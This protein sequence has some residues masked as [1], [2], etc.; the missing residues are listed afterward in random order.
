VR[1]HDGSWSERD[2]V[3]LEIT[4]R[5]PQ[6]YLFLPEG[7]V[8]LGSPVAERTG[9]V[10]VRTDPAGGVALAASVEGPLVYT[11]WVLRGDPPRYH[12]P[13]NTRGRRFKPHPEVL[14][15]ARDITDGVSGVGARAAAVEKHLQENY[16]YSLSGMAR[17]GPDPMTWF[18][19]RSREGH[20]EYFA[21]GMVVILDALGIPARMVG[22][23]SGGST[24]PSGEQVVVREANAHTWVEVWLGGDHGW[25]VFDPTPSIGVPSFRVAN[26][27]EQL[28]YAWEWVQA[29]WDRYVLT[30]G[31]GEQ[32]GLLSA[33]GEA[34]IRIFES[35]DWHHLAGLGAAGV[36][37]WVCIWTA[38]RM[39]WGSILVR[40][41][42]RRPPAAHAVELLRRRLERA[43]VDVPVGATVR[44]IGSAASSRWPEAAVGVSE[45]VWRAERELY[46]GRVADRRTEVRRLW[47][48]VRRAMG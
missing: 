23:Y 5:R 41:R 45:I 19:L 14:A 34:V 36:L 22:G 44:R 4:L 3:D 1:L 30:Y 33:V 31:L 35:L 48:E 16:S 2:T 11:V 42:L 8:A 10:T 43:G 17:I 12:D 37:L 7:T 15:L 25:E 47:H 28:R 9:P 27:R 39:R 46:S 38:R 6:R 20:C 32:I 18:L 21:G 13:P 40:R 26:R 29:S 24:S